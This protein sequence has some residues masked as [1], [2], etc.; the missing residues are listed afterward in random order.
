VQTV[1]KIMDQRAKL[2]GL[3]AAVGSASAS[4]ARNA[5]IGDGDRTMFDFAAV[6]VR[7]DVVPTISSVE[8]A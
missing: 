6:S 5:T 3:Y 1:L 7:G 4:Q 2:L 8:V